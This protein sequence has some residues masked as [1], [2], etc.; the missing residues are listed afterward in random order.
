MV[1]SARTQA[2]ETTYRRL[3]FLLSGDLKFNLDK[4]LVPNEKL[5][6]TP[7][8]WLRF[9]ATANTPSDILGAIEKLNYLRKSEVNRWDLNS[10]NPNRRKFLA[11]LGRR[12]TNQ[13][14]QRAAG[15]KRYPILIAFLKENYREVIDEIIE[16]FDRCLGDCHGRAKNDLKEHR[17][18]IAKA[19]NEKIV[20]FTNIGGLVLDKGVSDDQL[21]SMIYQVIPE[22]EFR[23]AMDECLQLIRPGD[24][25]AYDFLGNRY[26]YIREFSPQFLDALNF[27]SNRP[28]DPLLKALEVL[29][30]MNATGKRKVPAEAPTNFIQ[31]S[32][33]P[34]VKSDDG[35]TVRRYYE[36]STLWHL[37]NALRSGDI[38]VED[39]R[40][41]ADP[42]SYL[43][44]KDQWPAMRTEACRLLGLPENGGERIIE[45]QHELESVFSELDEKI[46]NQDG[47]RIEHDDLIISPLIAEELPPSVSKLQAMITDRLPRVD[48]TELLIETDRWTRFSDHFTHA[49]TRQPINTEL[50]ADLYASILAQANNHGLKKMAEISELSYP[51]LVWCSN[52]FLREE[53]LQSAI[54]NLVNYQFGQPL[55]ARWGGGTMSSSDGQRFPVA[56]KARNTAIIPKYYGYG[57]ILT[58]YSWTSDQHS[59]WRSKPVPSMTRDAT[60]VLDGM[61]DNETELPLFE[62]STDTAGYTELIFAL[63]DL[64]GF[65]FS[66]RIKDLAD[67]Q[68]YCVDK[69]IHYK[70]LEKIIKGTVKTDSVLMHW[71]TILRI[72]A[73]I[74][75]GWVTASLFVS[76]LQSQHRQGIIT[77]ALKEYGKLIKSIYIPKYIC[78]EE[79][80]RRVSLQLNK[81]EALHSLRRWLMFADEGQIRKSQL[82]DQANQASALT[83]VTNAIIVWNTRYMQ[84]VIDQLRSEGY[85]VA[86]E[87]LRHISPC[88]FEHINKH[89]KLNFDVEREW[90]RKKLRSLRKPGNSE[91]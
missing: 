26:S 17:I 69:K 36:I 61:I 49:S 21:R 78:R 1:I 3:E 47:V 41:Y 67:Q 44:P 57:R 32:W 13:S 46:L 70:T 7:L 43:I 2:Q 62:H 29:R 34:Y 88:R 14:L 5:G 16:L 53:T 33:L 91:I 58:Y 84:A 72:A 39:S 71:D 56:V 10:I 35:Q 25:H 86:E 9:G 68:I 63:F 28:N 4:I 74:R 65:M 54:N 8:A 75:L 19:A 45:R 38:W 60:Y 77:K 83:L 24:D 37:R 59:Q 85:D 90:S 23:E 55:A 51:R 87:D 81:G 18:S 80:Q 76:K 30:S 42:E 31:S 48:L 27:R 79:Q 6:R 50:S 82:Q 89:G 15:Q 11:Q 52:W 20:M 73:S 64:L 12:S 40:K 22:E 66:P